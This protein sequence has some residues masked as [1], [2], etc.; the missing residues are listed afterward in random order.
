MT[1]KELLL[2]KYFLPLL[3]LSLVA[4][5]IEVDISVPSF[6]AMVQ[7]FN[8]TDGVI[9]LTIAY[10]FFGACVAC[11]F[12]GP[13]SD[14]Y[15]RR[16]VMVWGNALLM[17]GAIGCAVA[18][19]L[20]WLLASRLVQGVGEAT[21]I[22]VVFSM[23]ADAYRGEK[24]IR[25][26][27]VMNSVLT[28]SMAIAPV[29]GAFVF[30]AVGW[31]GSYSVVAA[32][33]TLSWILLALFLPETHLNREPA[34]PR[35]ILRNYFRLFTSGKFMGASLVPS[36]LCAAYFA[37]IACAPFLYMETLG[38]SLLAY[39]LHQ[40]SV[41]GVY[42]GVSIVASR[43]STALGNRATVILGMVLTILG[44][45]AFVVAG[46]YEVTSPWWVTG[47]MIVFA[48]GF[49]LIYPVVF[50][51]S[52]EMFPSLKGTASS[53]IMGVRMFLMA[54]W[55]GLT[56]AFYDGAIIIPAGVVGVSTALALLGFIPLL[57]SPLLTRKG[58]ESHVHHHPA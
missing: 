48:I 52:M 32:V 19:N 6:P 37:F 28:V 46:L 14:A 8:T 15:G 26:I 2:N 41:V 21:S 44:A 29:L 18:T 56:S 1:N 33:C 10:N 20:S 27:G 55:V 9:Q 3:I 24:A 5:C 31:R 53:A 30:A 42:S 51:L 13:L 35:V 4:C 17:L 47:P 40:G 12:Y 38:L 34:A 45:G 58:E 25:Y 57:M 7:Y 43:I 54:V 16:S 39:A 23:M 49:A 22:V 50:T 11:L 36:V